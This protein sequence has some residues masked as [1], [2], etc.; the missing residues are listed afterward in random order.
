MFPGIR[1]KTVGMDFL[2]QLLLMH[3]CMDFL[4]ELERCSVIMMPVFALVPLACR[5][6]A[7]C[8]TGL[9]RQKIQIFQTLPARQ[10]MLMGTLDK[11]DVLSGI[12]L[13]GL[14]SSGTFSRTRVPQN[15]SK[16]GQ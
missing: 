8:R 16:K 10:M 9:T 12:F 5:G 7:L 1:Q 11:V 4:I 2:N 15:S 3:L 6:P 13:R 14:K